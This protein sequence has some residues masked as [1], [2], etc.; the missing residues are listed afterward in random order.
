MVL[1][2]CALV[3]VELWIGA[4]SGLVGKMKSEVAVVV[5]H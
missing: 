1:V 4:V 2:I 5:V 3:A